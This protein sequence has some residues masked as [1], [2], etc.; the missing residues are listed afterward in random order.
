MVSCLQNGIAWVRIQR[1][2]LPIGQDL[3]LDSSQ[4]DVAKAMRYQSENCIM[5][6][7]T[8]FADWLEQGIHCYLERIQWPCCK[9]QKA[10]SQ[11]DDRAFLSTAM[12]KQIQWTIQGLLEVDP[13][14]AEPPGGNLVLLRALVPSLRDTR[15]GPSFIRWRVL[16]LISCDGELQSSAAGLWWLVTQD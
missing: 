15:G 5:L 7:K 6:H 10:A 9:E 13:F 12:R 2:I 16:C 4:G 11:W 8:V 3:W 1:T 14:L